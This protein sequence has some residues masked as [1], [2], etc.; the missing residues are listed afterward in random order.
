[1]DPR[2][3]SI[4]ED[5]ATQLSAVRERLGHTEQELRSL[6][7]EEAKLETEILHLGDIAQRFSPMQEVPTA[8]NVIPISSEVDEKGIRGDWSELT[9][10][11]AVLAVLSSSTTPL[12]RH[13]IRERL[14]PHMR[15][16]H[17]A[18]ISAALSY[19]RRTRRAV[20]VD[21]NHW[22]AAPDGGSTAS[23]SSS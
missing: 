20:P 10:S 21:R 17:P 4:H 5:L 9:R 11:A 7:Q 8:Y 14:Q 16:D 19:L 1:M 12:T 23:R 22:R 13:A 2:F 15:D 18:D 3:E 6:R